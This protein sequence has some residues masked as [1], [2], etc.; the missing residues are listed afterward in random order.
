MISS[1]SFYSNPN[2][3]KKIR[4]RTIEENQQEDFCKVLQ[5]S[6]FAP[7]SENPNIQINSSQ[8]TVSGL[9]QA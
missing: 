6:F 2:L 9:L 7:E 3:L 4:I 1:K 8:N 5:N